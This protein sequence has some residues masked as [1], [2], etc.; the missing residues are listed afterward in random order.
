[1][2]VTGG[3]NVTSAAAG[4]INGNSVAVTGTSGNVTLAGTVTA[5]TTTVAIIAGNDITTSNTVIAQT[6]VTMTAD[7]D[8]A[9][10]NN[11]TAT[12]GNVDITAGRDMEQT[13]GQIQAIAGGVRV[14]AGR[15]IDVINI[16][17][18][19]NNFGTDAIKLTADGNVGITGTGLTATGPAG[20]NIS[21]DPVDVA[22]GAA[23]MAT[24]DVTV[25]ADNNI[26]VTAAVTADS[27]NDNTGNANLTADNDSSSAGDFVST[28]AT[29]VGENVTIGGYNVA[30]GVLTADF[31]G[32]GDGDVIVNAQN[33]ATLNGAVTGGDL[34]GGTI[35]INAVAGNAV[36]AAGGTL[37]A[38]GAITVDAGLDITLGTTVDSE[39]ANVA[40]TSGNDTDINGTITAETGVTVNA[41]NNVSIDANILADENGGN[42]GD[43]TINADA[44]NSSAG[45]VTMGD[46]TI[47][48]DDIEI[49]GQ[50][51]QVDA[52]T[53]DNTGTGVMNAAGD[54]TVTADNNV[55]LNDTLTAG[56]DASSDIEVNGIEGIVTQQGAGSDMLAGGDVTVTGGAGVD[57][58]G[59]VG[60]GT[61]IGNNVTLASALGSIDTDGT[62]DADNNVIMSA[63]QDVT[64]AG[65]VTAGGFINIAG[66]HDVTTT[67]LLDTN[68]NAGTT[69][70]VT[71]GQ[72]AALDE[73]DAEGMVTLAAGQN[74]TLDGTVDSATSDVNAGAGGNLD[75]NAAIGSDLNTVNVNLVA[76]TGHIITTDTIDATTN[77]T[78]DAG[79]EVTL[80][81][82]VTAVAGHV[83]IAAGW[84]IDMSGNNITAATHVDM[85]SSDGAII[86]GG[87]LITVP[88][89]DMGAATGIDVD[90]DVTTVEAVN[91]ASGDV[92]IIEADT[93]STN[94]LTVDGN[95]VTNSGNGT[96]TID[97]PLDLT[98]NAGISAGGNVD[99]DAD[100]NININSTSVTSIAGYVDLY[101]DNNNIDISDS[102][103]NSGTN[104]SIESEYDVDIDNSILRA[105]T[106][107]YIEGRNEDVEIYNGS[108]I[109]AGTYVDIYADDSI[110]VQGSSRIDAGTSVYMEATDYEVIVTDSDIGAGTYVDM[111]SGDS[112]VELSNARVTAGDYV[113]LD[114]DEYVDVVSS[115]LRAGTYVEIDGRNDNV[116]I[117]DSDIGADTY[118]DIASWNTVTI[119]NSS[120]ITAGTSVYVENTNYQIDL[121]DSAIDAGTSVD[122]IANDGDLTID[123]SS[124][125]AGSYADL[126]SYYRTYIVDSDINTGTYFATWADSSYVEV[127][128][129]TVKAED[130]VDVYADTY[131]DITDSDIGADTDVDVYTNS[132]SIYID[133]SVVTGGGHVDIFANN[134]YIYML[135][136]LV[137]AG[138]YAS[139]SADGSVDIYTSDINAGEYAQIYSNASYVYI[140]DAPITAGTSVDITADTSVDIIGSTIDSSIGSG[141]YTEIYSNNSYVYLENAP[142]AAGTYVDIVADDSIELNASSITANSG[143]ISLTSY[144]SYIDAYSGSPLLAGGSVN[145]TADTSIWTEDDVTAITGHIDMEANSGDIDVDGNLT[146][147]DYVELTADNTVNLNGD[148]DAGG[149][150]DIDADDDVNIDAD[151]TVNGSSTINITADSNQG[152]VGNLNIAQNDLSSITSI[153]GDITLQGEDINVGSGANTGVVRTVGNG[154]IK[155]T[156]NYEFANTADLTGGSFTL[157]GTESEIDSGGSIDID[158][159]FDVT[160]GGDGMHAEGNI[161]IVAINDIDINAP[162]NST[163]AGDITMTAG[164]DLLLSDEVRTTDTGDVTLEATAGVIDDDDAGTEDEYVAGDTVTMTAANGIGITTSDIDIEANTI[165][166]DTTGAG[167]AGIDIENTN[168]QS[169]FTTLA[170]VGTLADI[171]FDQTGGGGLTVDSATTTDGDITITNNG[172]SATQGI[173]AII[174]DANGATSDVT[175]YT[176][177]GG[178]ILRSVLADDDINII[179]DYGDIS[180]DVVGNPSPIVLGRDVTITAT[181]GYIDELVTMVPPAQTQDAA[182]DITGDVVTLRAGIGIGKKYE[183]EID[184]NVLDAT[185]SSSSGDIFILDPNDV[186]LANASTVDGNITITAGGYIDVRNISANGL[187]TDITLTSL[188]T[189]GTD[190]AHIWLNSA[191]ADD[192]ITVTTFDV[193][194][195][196]YVGTV[197]DAGT[198]D[199]FMTATNGSIFE[200]NGSPN[201]PVLVRPQDGATDITGDE[202]TLIALN[203]IGGTGEAD[204]ETSVRTLTADSTLLGDIILTETDDGTLGNNGIVL[205]SVDTNDGDII[206]ITNGLAFETGAATTVVD[207]QSDTGNGDDTGTHDIS[208]DAQSGDMEV[209]FIHSDDDVYLGAT[210]AGGRIVEYNT[211]D[212][213]LGDQDVDIQGEL[214]M[215]EAGAGIGTDDYDRPENRLDTQVNELAAITQS[216]DINIENTGALT[217]VDSSVAFGFANDGAFTGPDG[218]SITGGNG[219][220][221]TDDN[222]TVI[223]SSPLTVALGAPVLDAVGGDILLVADGTTAADIM[224]INDDITASGGNGNITLYAGND[225][226]QDAG[227]AGDV[228][229][230]AAGSGSISMYAGVDWNAGIPRAGYAGAGFSDITMDALA[231]I[232]SGSGNIMMTAT[233]NITI[234]A[235]STAGD[236]T[237]S[238]DDN[239][240]LLG[241]NV[242]AITEVLAAETAV[243]TAD[244]LIMRA[245]TGIGSANDID[246]NVRTV[247]ATNSISGN[248]NIYEVGT[249]NDLI[250]LG[251][252]NST[253]TAGNV[254]IQ[255]NDGT[256]TVNGAVSTA[257]PASTITLIAHDANTTND[258]DLNI[259]AAV[260]AVNGTVTLTSDTNDVNFAAAGDV[261]TTSGY[262]D[263]NA[264]G[265][266]GVGRIFMADGAMINSG[267]DLITMDA[268]GDITI[269]GV[270][271]TNATSTAIVITT[272][273]GGVIDGGDADIDIEADS[274]RVVIDAVTGVGSTLVDVDPDP[275]VVNPADAALETAVASIDVDNTTSGDIR[276]DEVNAITVI[277]LDNDADLGDI[278][279]T[280]GGTITVDD[281]AAGGLG[282]IAI[283]GDI[284]LDANG[285]T[286]DVILENV[287]TT[288]TGS[289]TGGSITISADNDVMLVDTASSDGDVTALGAGNVTITADADGVADGASGQVHM[290]NQIL[291]NAGSG[292]IIVSADEDITL[293]GLLTTN[294]TN[295]TGNGAVELTST[296]AGIVD[297]GD[298]FVDVV[299]ASGRLLTQTV[300]GV[301]RAGSASGGAAT[302]AIETTVLGVEMENTVSGNIDIAETDAMN[303]YK[304]VQMSP[305]QTDNNGFIRVV[306]TNGTITVVDNSDDTEPVIIAVDGSGV[307]DGGS[308]RLTAGGAASDVVI[309]DGITTEEGYVTITSNDS[310]TFGNTA[311]GRNGFI[312]SPAEG[313]VSIIANADGV[314]A[315]SD[316]DRIFM[317]NG[318]TITS[319]TGTITMSTATGI[320]GGDITLTGLKTSN[321]TNTAV[322]I[323]SEAA[324]IDGGDTNIDIDANNGRVVITAATGVG[325]AA[326]SGTDVAIETSANSLDVE[327]V[328]NATNTADG[329]I[330]IDETDDVTVIQLDNDATNADGGSEGDIRL[331]T[332]GS[333]ITIADES[334]GGLGVVAVDG[335][336]LLD[337]NGSAGSIFSYA[338]IT[339]A[340][341]HAVQILANDHVGL[342][343]GTA[344]VTSSGEGSVT[345]RANENNN[346]SG[347]GSVSMHTDSSITADA[348]TVSGF[349]VQVDTLT[350]DIS[351]GADDGTIDIDA[352]YNVVLND[353]LTA[354]PGTSSDILITA[355]EGDVTQTAGNMLA[356]RNVDIDGREGVTLNG[357]IGT[358]TAIGNDVFI[359]SSMGSV[360]IIDDITA[361]DDIFVN[362]A[363][364]IVVGGVSADADITA[365]NN[366]SGAGNVNMN[367]D[368]D[369]SSA[370]DL[371]IY[372]NSAITGEQVILT[373]RNVTSDVV[374]ARNGSNAAG[375]MITISGENDVTINDN[376]TV[377][378]IVNGDIDITATEGS[379]NQTAGT[380]LATDGGVEISAGDDIDVIA[381]TANANNMTGS[382][383]AIKLT[384]GGD[385]NVNSGST[386]LVAVD[387]LAVINPNLNIS[388][389]PWNVNINSAVSASGN[390][391]VVA[392][393]N[394]TVNAV[395]TADAGVA[396]NVGDVD[397]RADIDSSSAGD[398]ES[399]ALITGENIR[400]DGYNIRTSGVAAELT[401]DRAGDGAGNVDVNAQNNATIGDAVTAGQT[402]GTIDIDGTEG[403][404]TT[405]A[406]G[407]LDAG[408][409]ITVTAGL[410]IT[411]GD[412]VDTENDQ[413]T[414]TAGHDITIN[415]TVTAED[416]GGDATGNGIIMTADNNVAINADLTSDED[417][418][419]N[420]DVRIS[421]DADSDSAGDVTMGAA[422]T[423]RGDDINVSGYN[424]QVD[425]ILA[426][427]STGVATM[428]TNGNITITAE[429]NA[430][431]DDNLTAGTSLGLAASDITITATEG[432]ATQTAGDMTAGRDVSIS[433][434]AGVD[435]NGTIGNVTNIGRDVLITSS[436]GSVDIDEL[437]DANRHVTVNA[438]NNIDVNGIVTADAG[439]ADNDGD[440]TMTADSDS[441]SAGDLESTDLITG[442]NITLN[443]YNVRTFGAA[444][445]LTADRAGDGAGNVTVTAQDNATFGD[446][447][448]AGQ[449]S[450]MIT[451]TATA[452]N[453]MTGAAGSLDAGGNI[454]VTAG[455]DI[456]IGDFVD[457]ENDQVTMTAGHD[458]TINDTVT[459]EDDGGD[460]TGNGIIMTADNNVAIASG[461]VLRADED[462]GNNGDVDIDADADSDSAGDVTMGAGSVIYGD[463]INIA[464]YNVQVMT[465]TAD[466]TGAPAVMDG[467]GDITVHAQNNATFNNNLTAGTSAASDIDLDADEGFANQTAGN[468]LAGGN[469]Y[470]NGGSG[471]NLDGTIGA[472]TAIGIDVDIESAYGSV[473]IDGNI[474]AN[475]DVFVDAANNIV[476]GNSADITADN[477]L[478]DLGDVVMNAD[479]DSSSAGDL[480]INDDSTITGERVTLTGY[481]VTSDVVTARNGSDTAGTK[482]TITG[483]HDVTIND[484]T[485][486][487]SAVNGDIEITSTQGSTNQTAGTILATNGG[488]EIVAGK[489][490]DVIEVVANANNMPNAAGTPGTTAIKLTA[491]GDIRV[492]ASG[493][494]YGLDARDGTE[495]L[496]IDIDPYDVTISNQVIANGSVTVVADNNITVNDIVTAD[497]DSDNAGDVDMRA[498]ID[499]DSSG[500][501]ESTA[502]ITGENIRID[503]YNI[504]TNGAAAEL[505]ADR[506]IDGSGN[507][508]L[509]AQ[510]NAT[511][512]DAVLAG[513]T[514]GTID[515][516]G[517]EG[518]VTTGAAGSLDAGGNITVTA[519]LDITIGDFVDSENDQIT[520]TAGHDITINDTLTAEDDG[521]V[522]T[523]DGTGNGIIITADNN[524]SINADLTADENGGDNG[525]VRIAADADS[526]SAGDVTMGDFIVR[527]DDINVSGY[528]VQ[529]DRI[530][531]DTTTGTTRMD[532]AGD[533]TITA[534]NNARMSDDLWAGTGSASDID[535]DANEGVAWQSAGNM[536][537]GGN[538]TIDGGLNRKRNCYLHNRQYGSG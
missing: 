414:M 450:G 258:E 194:G 54:I 378:S 84:D 457:T 351:G 448:T 433:G 491:D 152:G 154:D 421:A 323:N 387:T 535:I 318:A 86:G 159:P 214:L 428:D 472:T 186:M 452:G 235:I 311:G 364:S 286:S 273:A 527:G 279:L 427:T 322:T 58:N 179:A 157:A 470:I 112:S 355:A 435:L 74:M 501:F 361:N 358:G 314:S 292:Q 166:A 148:I 326:G 139:V 165:L 371:T 239:T 82:D 160:I 329:D 89:L 489:D 218:V 175:L 76:E 488:V 64:V 445:E 187:G 508:D 199:I 234:G 340:G 331:T 415:D 56:T 42:D 70:T 434:G 468:M 308:V 388:I 14:V 270:K 422:F 45:N 174:I 425:R 155:I 24:G 116:Y 203:D 296:S 485:T 469:V 345:V 65:D 120:S 5:D 534:Q 271:T 440:V 26:T 537:A 30:A 419:N 114:A 324:V 338:A 62:I 320:A 176:D 90:T 313:N 250:V 131:V 420:G 480:T 232:T 533:I 341:D 532:T 464:G 216:G 413:V 529:V 476:V 4:A 60:S 47:Y 538:V 344:D 68:T 294:A 200:H 255:T 49:T 375:T 153:D 19:A 407:S 477:N 173:D 197:G 178:M 222:I 180:I 118:V 95:G 473:S 130:Y 325:N 281:A 429:N 7:E 17:A 92:E 259:N 275:D 395:V 8:A 133:N 21:I 83:E 266:A 211:T 228:A 146:A 193:G 372:N 475:D 456:T 467:N 272:T 251:A 88:D 282:V 300:T 149:Y 509:N 172:A 210:A 132:S 224:T 487:V 301:G 34:V 432:M 398:L 356:G 63:G 136:T 98:I 498:D 23:V 437:I 392:D 349:N 394:I 220:E 418:G 453:A 288:G 309:N 291:V 360:D 189:G 236:V 353:N 293:G 454:T 402:S 202:L 99:L 330:N 444:A 184:A 354:G 439:V 18:N 274:G 170:T 230:T 182:V 317:A 213:P 101:V 451:V 206:L 474:T 289:G 352:I 335:D 73:I 376:T 38:G 128:N 11:V 455:L 167:A 27:D 346:D 460:A 198:D 446:A 264:M 481:N 265:V 33:N 244:D 525:D 233:E 315:A 515:I 321:N 283:G 9:V 524:V 168:S 396:D 191:F 374:T 246:T 103:I 240:Y 243:V 238:A 209:N 147:A 126:Y 121:L 431:M 393:N 50:N 171:N 486:V 536:L 229:V 188:G 263:V 80:G 61:T 201:I 459:A 36:T 2:T 462:G 111:Y 163:M 390:V 53:A 408:G 359:D 71:A 190:P 514:D 37:D 55:T 105:G 32:V 510:N 442:E 405:G 333:T 261:T 465:L 204:I 391:T 127:N 276:I 96:V 72:D 205:E 366:L 523:T 249:D 207:V 327:N 119:Q 48:G 110:E 257:G 385:V 403:N 237:I 10:S 108:D 438:A 66:G 526:D 406:A 443:G 410:D 380:I 494:T 401:A 117:D 57:L 69:I 81:D 299:A 3:R 212:Q 312:S 277:Q 123:T 104:T 497:A 102:S 16:D 15:D 107:V 507:V 368:T 245:A 29:I 219:L 339:T 158:P 177:A 20:L 196:I 161:D 39:L 122:M 369:S 522:V 75:I 43:V 516:D 430:R 332:A 253:A 164:N 424:V 268:R 295:S 304:I 140:E 492:N 247:L 336:I 417:G 381:V 303:I 483:E 252:T 500:D 106:N 262:V 493:V 278:A 307:V 208:I 51:V 215:L 357:T 25:V 1:A 382:T 242:G 531:A 185:T 181:N 350:A 280:A 478:S 404:V 12:T 137:R 290:D 254:D 67:A 142:I 334:V 411:I 13:A 503:G 302:D 365:D 78:M 143:N 305:E 436:I 221:T 225:I 363:N 412:F 306:T 520:M 115:V 141:T 109:G 6:S 383:N 521:S 135:D 513:Q 41:D 284:L 377:S 449:T 94:G 79:E 463:D 77:I 316:G 482:I 517:T 46:F 87:G 423:I 156:A 226:I 348:I 466:N 370:G 40:L 530:Y 461:V 169:T 362:A 502:L 297:G 151:I 217:I 505:T 399:T 328:T 458:I 195:N 409:N 260:T 125:N 162:V 22:I 343:D 511:I 389:D 490:I 319:G 337:A 145:I 85:F 223:A 241:N 367:A 504:R 484:N 267:D 499:S 379:V 347:T 373:G 248:I 31:N 269:G 52:L 59:T 310:V 528:N 342:M 471:V 287:V 495:E 44:D 144:N 124:I 231:T 113:H 397:M 479:T 447:V 227:V 285:A 512:G 138:E 97:T 150:V 416:D 192:D 298:A 518:N 35:D 496:N 93:V 506:A 386:G 400:L 256:L 28:G 129:S 134:D 183:L 384:A 426:D 100:D 441:S 519:G 91:T